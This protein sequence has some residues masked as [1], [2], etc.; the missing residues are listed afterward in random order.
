MPRRVPRACRARPASCH[1][2]TGRPP[3]VTPPLAALPPVTRPPLAAPPAVTPPLAA[4]PPVTPP[5]AAPPPV[6]TPLA[7]RHLSCPHW[8]LRHLSRP[9][10]PLRQ[11]SRPHWPPSRVPAQMPRRVPR[12]CRARREP[13]D[14]S[15][16]PSAVGTLGSWRW[17]PP[18]CPTRPERDTGEVSTTS[19]GTTSP[20]G[21]PHPCPRPR[22]AKGTCPRDRRRHAAGII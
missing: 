10:W 22:R 3:A 15:P 2:P 11:L 16:A 7:A 6:T 17:L 5:L 20:A 14:A 19:T 13:T 8:P 18:I 1:A 12:T 21:I 9:H 4:L